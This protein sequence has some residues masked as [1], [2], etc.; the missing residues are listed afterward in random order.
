MAFKLMKVTAVQ[1]HDLG[2]VITKIIKMLAR[3]IYVALLAIYLGPELLGL[4][5]YSHHWYV[6]FFPLAVF[7]MPMVL[8]HEIG[9]YVD[10]REQKIRVSVASRLLTTIAAATACLGIALFIEK[11]TQAR[12][13]ICILT[14]A[15]IA[16]SFSTWGNHV[17]VVMESAAPIPWITATGRLTELLAAWILLQL[18]FSVIALAWLHVVSYVGEA[19]AFYILLRRRRVSLRP[20]FDVSQ[21]RRF[22]A[23]GALAGG[24]GFLQGLFHTAPVLLFRWFGGFGEQLGN[25][26]LAFQVLSMLILVPKAINKA[27]LPR[28]SRKDQSTLK[29]RDTYLRLLSVYGTLALFLVCLFTSLVGVPITQYFISSEYA[30]LLELTQ[31]A[32]WGLI[33]LFWALS[34]QQILGS[35]AYFFQNALTIFV[36][37]A[38]TMMTIA[39]GYSSFGVLIVAYAYLIGSSSWAIVGWLFVLD[40]RL[41]LRRQSN[42]SNN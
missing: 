39:L 9:R 26:S 2:L 15:L 42:Q 20:L 33:P 40:R 12:E 25:V 30:L 6:I 22:F 32:V 28:M 4:L 36:A 10:S 24:A 13:L 18:D 41:V 17:C 23:L 3:G 31:I 5:N 1:G 19:M 34:A 14:F 7:G 11:E 21:I 8:S 29:R 38:A 16:R 35:Q 27:L 37:V